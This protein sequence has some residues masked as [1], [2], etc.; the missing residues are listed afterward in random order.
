MDEHNNSSDRL[1]LFDFQD[2]FKGV[3]KLLP[4]FLAYL[5]T[6]GAPRG[7]QEDAC[8][9]ALEYTYH[10]CDGHRVRLRAVARRY[11]APERL[12]AVIAKRLERL[13]QPAACGESQHDGGDTH[14]M[15]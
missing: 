5:E 15:H 14:E 11:G 3:R 8:A 13:V 12:C 6:Y 7:R 10:R 9:A 4:L 2:V 1:S